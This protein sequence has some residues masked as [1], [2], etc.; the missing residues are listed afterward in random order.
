MTVYVI[1][2]SRCTDRAAF[3]RFQDSFLGVF[4]CCPKSLRVA[5]D[6]L[7]IGAESA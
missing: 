6:S 3:D 4:R 1:A 7:Q 2:Q 5:R